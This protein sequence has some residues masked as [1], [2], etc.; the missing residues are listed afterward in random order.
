MSETENHKGK[1]R[2]VPLLDG[3]SLEEQCERICIL[4]SCRFDQR[5]HN[6]WVDCLIDEAYSEFIIVNNILFEIYDHKRFDD[7]SFEVTEDPDG[8]Y[9]FVGSFY[10]GGTCLSEMLEDGL[11]QII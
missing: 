4:N 8:T 2:I 3:E 6:T 7:Y 11:L 1:L 9:S 5:Y 10:N